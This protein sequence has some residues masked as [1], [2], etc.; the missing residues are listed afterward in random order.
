MG[1]L[2]ARGFRHSGRA[3]NRFLARPEE[4]S[5]PQAEITRDK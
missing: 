2:S 5:L 1:V 4:K 3:R